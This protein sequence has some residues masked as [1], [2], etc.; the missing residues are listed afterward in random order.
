MAI[1]EREISE[2]LFSL[3]KAIEWNEGVKAIL[4]YVGC[5]SLK[6]ADLLEKS[7]KYLV[8]DAEVNLEE[9]QELVELNPLNSSED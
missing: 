4:M 3:A 5:D 1:I 8:S 6:H 7:A 2:F 9:C